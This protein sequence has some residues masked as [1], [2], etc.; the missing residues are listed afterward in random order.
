MEITHAD[1]QYVLLTSNEP[2]GKRG[3][4]EHKVLRTC[5][6][7]LVVR[8]ACG[9]EGRILDR[10]VAWTLGK[11][12]LRNNAEQSTP[13]T[14]PLINKKVQNAIVDALNIGAQNRDDEFSGLAI[15]MLEQLE[16]EDIVRS[17]LKSLDNPNSLM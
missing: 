12:L 15:D 10:E 5:V 13:Y 11:Y 8:A 17:S 2:V 6:T 3:Y 1:G 14:A 16:T 9:H 4:T 7:Y